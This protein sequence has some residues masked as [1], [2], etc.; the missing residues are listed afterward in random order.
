MIGKENGADNVFTDIAA[1][2]NAG[3]SH[4]GKYSCQDDRKELREGKLLT[5]HA[6]NKGD[7]QYAGETGTIHMHGSPKRDD[8][9]CDIFRDARLRGFLKI[10]GNGRHSLTRRFRDITGF[11]PHRY[12][13]EKRINRAFLLIQD[14]MNANEAAEKCGFTD[15]STFYRIYRKTFGQGPGKKEI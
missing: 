15:Y 1:A 9:I 3:H 12:I 13:C 5:E 8:H 6:E 7:L 11:T 10:C 4:R 14:G 2:R